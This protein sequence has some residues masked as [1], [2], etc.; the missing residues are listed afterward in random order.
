MSNG[1]THHFKEITFQSKHI[2]TNLMFLDTTKLG[3]VIQILLHLVM[4][5]LDFLILVIDKT[6]NGDH[7]AKQVPPKYFP[8]NSPL[9]W[10]VWCLVCQKK[11]RATKALCQI[12]YDEPKTPLIL[13]RITNISRRV[14]FRFCLFMTKCFPIVVIHMYFNSCKIRMSIYWRS[15][16]AFPP[17]NMLK[18]NRFISHKEFLESNQPHY[19][20]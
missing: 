5:T 15:C 18:L 4:Y 19:H 20:Q 8:E 16:N 10:L 2:F 17:Y 9:S 7:L 11:A 14:C 3:I 1:L 6:Q 13:F 12:T